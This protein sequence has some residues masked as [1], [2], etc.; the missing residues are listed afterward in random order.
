MNFIT[1]TISHLSAQN[2]PT[3]MGKTVADAICR[4]YEKVVCHDV[5]LREQDIAIEGEEH[6]P[7][8]TGTIL[9]DHLDHRHQSQDPIPDILGSP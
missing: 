6:D 9:M 1:V 3:A 4:S 5:F 7:K 2:E 8:L